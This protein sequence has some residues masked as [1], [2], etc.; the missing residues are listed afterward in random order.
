M[1][2]VEGEIIDPQPPEERRP[3]PGRSFYHPLS[4]AV[5]LAVDWACF[6]LDFFTGFGAI[7]F[8]STLAFCVTFYAVLTIQRRLRGD[9]PGPA[10]AKALLGAVAAGLPFPIFGTIVGAA[11]LALSGLPSLRR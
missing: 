10:L 9:A 11:I 2:E 4:G 1:K 5:I 6:G 3:A 8:A 7:L